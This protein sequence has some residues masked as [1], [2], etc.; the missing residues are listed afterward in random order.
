MTCHICFD[1][2]PVKAQNSFDVGSLVSH[3]QRQNLLMEFADE[4]WAADVLRQQ[5]GYVLTD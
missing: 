2:K 3:R 5:V 1:V 4:V